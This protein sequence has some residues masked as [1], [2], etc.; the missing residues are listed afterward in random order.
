MAHSVLHQ[1]VHKYGLTQAQAQQVW[2]MA[3]QERQSVPWPLYLQRTLAVLAA[4]LLGSGLIFW[5]AAQ[6]QGLARSQQLLLLQAAVLLPLV[7]AAFW[8]R[9]RTAAL[10]LAVLA[11]GGLL[12]FVG[13]TYQTGADAWQLFAAWAAL[14][15]V[16]VL[17]ARS[18]GLWALWLLIAGAGL[19]LWSSP[20]LLGQ[21]EFMFGRYLPS[22]ALPL[23]WGAFAAWPW[24]LGKLPWGLS[25][26]RASLSRR[27]AAAWA[28][29][30][31]TGLGLW[32]LWSANKGAATVWLSVAWV[33]IVL[34]QAWYRA[35]RDLLVL[36]M[37]LLAANMLFLS[38]A[39]KLLFTHKL[40]WLGALV[41]FN[42]LCLLC[43]G[44]SASWLYRLHKQEVQ[45]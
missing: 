45:A 11:L 14:A 36:A 16:W 43:L 20:G 18:D 22:A 33:L 10:L 19:A 1:V 21:W 28:L 26:P 34:W 37:A 12:A 40:E 29:S 5:V 39:A 15:L 31:W 27:L 17:L 2:D 32:V 24:V 8:P 30:A 35:W 38:A 9:W 3:A 4:L 42:G 13:Q 7:L 25:V 23:L 44:G 41:V 6:W